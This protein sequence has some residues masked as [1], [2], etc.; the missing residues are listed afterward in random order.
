MNPAPVAVAKNSSSVVCT[1]TGEGMNE[2]SRTYYI[3]NNRKIA[4]YRVL[5]LQRSD[6]CGYTH[7][8]T[9]ATLSTL[10]GN[11]QPWRFFYACVKAIQPGNGHG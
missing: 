4:H 11:A 10:W 7:I 2:N 3:S 9:T 6:S 5:R 8:N 1:D